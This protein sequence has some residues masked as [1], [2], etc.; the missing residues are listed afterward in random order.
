M[1]VD[2]AELAAGGRG[3]LKPPL[4]VKFFYGLGE[5]AQSGVFNTAIPFVFFYYTAVLGLS[6]GLVGAALAISLGVDAVVDP[7]IGSWS[8]NIASRLGRRLPLMIVATPLMCVAL[9]LLFSP[10]ARLAQP[11]LFGWLTATSIA[12]RSLISLFNVPYITLGAEMAEGYAERSKVVAWRTVAG[13]VFGVLIT[14]L[15]FTVFFAKAPGLLRAKGYPAFGWSVAL[16]LLIAATI[17]CAGV[18][19]Y[20]GRLPRAPTVAASIWR[21]LPA[22]LAEIFRNG[23]FRI[24]FFS[25]VITWVAVGANGT[26]DNH[27]RMFVWKLTP[28]M[29][30]SLGYVYLA[31][32]LAGVALAP[33]LARR[34]EKKAMVFTGLTMILVVLTVLPLLRASGL[35]TPTGL[36]ALAPLG[37]S[38]V[39]SGMGVGFVAIAFPSMMA[40]AADEHEL[41]FG[42]RRE[43]LYFSGLG[44]AMKAASGMGAL[45][46]GSALTLLRFPHDAGHAGVTASPATLDGLILAWGP[47]PAVLI[48]AG[49]AVTWRYAIDRRRHDAITAQLKARRG[50]ARSLAAP[51]RRSKRLRS[52]A[53]GELNA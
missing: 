13:I 36:S 28:W 8:D 1:D 51:E 41:L 2:G 17:C 14:A 22:E 35:Y 53:G 52:P 24:L 42:A 44:F 3:E 5:M 25:G 34:I 31:S 19:R 46:G 6:G 9:V 12:V 4:H 49:M 47:V 37:V 10:P 50:G 18:A 32:M 43:G 21:R 29:M 40:D 23:S 11:V 38:S 33:Q 48:A 7:L 30:Q 20:A 15:A 27:V 26:L 39:F 45:I 16:L